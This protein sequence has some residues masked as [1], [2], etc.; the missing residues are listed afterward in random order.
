MGPRLIELPCLTNG[1]KF[2]LATKYSFSPP[3]STTLEK[4]EDVAD[5][6]HAKYFGYSCC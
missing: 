4:L 2:L 1:I 6:G 5:A 3:A